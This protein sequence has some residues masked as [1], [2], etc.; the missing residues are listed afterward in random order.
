MRLSI[1]KE[2]FL[3]ALNVTSKAIANKSADPLLANLKL[4]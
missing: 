4:D 3:K 1:D 2:Q